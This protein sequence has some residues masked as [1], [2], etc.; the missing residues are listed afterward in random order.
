LGGLDLTVDGRSIRFPRGQV[1]LALSTLLVRAPKSV[2]AD[3]IIDELWGDTWPDNAR[4]GLQQVVSSIRRV[5]NRAEPG[6]G[7][8]LIHTETTGY[9]IDIPASRIDLRRFD[10]LHGAARA[11]QHPR[12]ALRLVDEAL[13]LWRG[14]P[15]AGLDGRHLLRAEAARLTEMRA[16]AVDLRIEALL[17]LGH[18]EMAVTELQSIVLR[19]P[20]RENRWAL[21]MLGLYR[22]GRQS[23]ALQTMQRVRHMLAEITGLVPG[24]RLRE[25]E[26]QILAHDD[27]LLAS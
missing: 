14:E 20:L 16:D 7:N 9:R 8:E 26:A 15:F 24:P 22:L 21:L 25:L 6:L 11:Q 19:T 3:A 10:E 12:R 23:E 18:T 27:Q 13:G 5:L 17:E 1:E 4:N 2:T